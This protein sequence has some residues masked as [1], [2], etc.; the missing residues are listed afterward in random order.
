MKILSILIPTIPERAE[1]FTRVYSELMKQV[2]FMQTVHPTLGEVE[3]LVDS[4]TKFINGGLSIG[5]KREAMVQR[6]EGKYL[7]FLDDDE[8]I[9]PNYLEILVRMCN[10]DKDVCCFR[11]ISKLDNF[12]MVVDMNLFFDNEAAMPG[13][14]QRRPWH[15]CPVRSH[16]AQQHEFSDINYGEDWDWFE[17]VLKQCNNQARSFAIIHQYNHGKHSESDKIMK[18]AQSEQ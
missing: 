15:I 1:M 18:H 5:K 2:A 14:I 17:K 16:L 12:W 13:I 3:V 4:S 7:C 10:E 9:A 11:N 6:A 8:T